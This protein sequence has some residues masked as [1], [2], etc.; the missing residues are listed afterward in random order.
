MSPLALVS[1]DNILS[2]TALPMQYQSAL[3]GGWF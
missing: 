1:G 3:R 2:V